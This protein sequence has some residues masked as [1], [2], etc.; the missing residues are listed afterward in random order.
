MQ[1]SNREKSYRKSYAQW[2]NHVKEFNERLQCVVCSEK[3]L[4]WKIKAKKENVNIRAHATIC[5]Q[6]HNSKRAAHSRNIRA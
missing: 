4:F 3:E 5:E 1:S 6:R 2:N